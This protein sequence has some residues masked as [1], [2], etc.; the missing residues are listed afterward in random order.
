LAVLDRR[1]VTALRGTRRG[2][3][4]K[5]AA[6][7]TFSAEDVVPGEEG[8]TPVLGRPGSSP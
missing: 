5:R 8:Q 7:L 6:R 4:F 2:I 1:G 3:S